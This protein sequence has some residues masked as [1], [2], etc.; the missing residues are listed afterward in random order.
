MTGQRWQYAVVN[1]GTFNTA[2]RLVT[3]LG[4]L[5]ADRWELVHVY[6][7]A[8]N[9]LTGMEKGFALFKRPVADGDEPDG[10]WAVTL[11]KNG[12]LVVPQDW[13]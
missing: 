8:S 13:F 9:W 11:D 6:D 12:D 4:K 7:K 1:V 3:I 10:G 2:E 5:G